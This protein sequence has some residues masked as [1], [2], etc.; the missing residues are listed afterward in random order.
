MMVGPHLE[1]M[2]GKILWS[3]PKKLFLTVSHLLQLA[4]TKKVVVPGV[5]KVLA[6]GLPAR[7]MQ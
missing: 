6:S 2:N 4:V 7:L 5:R 1:S 3:I